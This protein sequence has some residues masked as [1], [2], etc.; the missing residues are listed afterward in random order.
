M[1]DAAA[2]ATRV[3]LHRN[4]EPETMPLASIGA[5]SPILK[6]APKAG[7]K[8]IIRRHESVSDKI[9]R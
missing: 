1:P 8:M 6:F 4:S 5:P 2:V 7:H 9:W 3:M